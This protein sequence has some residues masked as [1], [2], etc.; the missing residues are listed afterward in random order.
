M[1][2]FC[3]IK[4]YCADHLQWIQTVIEHRAPMARLMKQN[5]TTLNKGSNK[6]KTLLQFPVFIVDLLQTLTKKKKDD[7]LISVINEHG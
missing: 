5:S 4:Q 1:K 7:I 2:I 6:E 3:S